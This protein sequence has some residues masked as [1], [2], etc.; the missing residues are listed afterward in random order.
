MGNKSY[1]TPPDFFKV[2]N[3]EFSF[4]L[5]AAASH[6]NALCDTYFTEDGLWIKTMGKGYTKISPYNGLVGGWGGDIVFCNPPYTNI[7]KWLEKVEQ[8]TKAVYILPASVDTKWYHN[9]FQDMA[10]T[11]VDKVE[12]W[13]YDW[14]CTYIPKNSNPRF[15]TKDL[16]IY[17]LQGRMNFWRDG[18]PDTVPRN[19]TIV[20]VFE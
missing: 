10:I 15:F 1:Q 9:L 20:L 2:L 6:N 11:L 4:T 14:L 18:K 12:R 7:S 19:G 3:D 17:T 5:D 8:S 13:S 16:R